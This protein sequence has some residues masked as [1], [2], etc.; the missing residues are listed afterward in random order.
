VEDWRF[1]PRIPHLVAA[2]LGMF[3]GVAA[4]QAVHISSGK[5][6]TW[7]SLLADVLILGIILLIVMY[8]NYMK[9]MSLEGIALLSAALA[10]WGPKGIA[11]LLERFKRVVL[12]TAD[13][14]LRQSVGQSLREAE[15][16]PL[17]EELPEDQAKLLDRLD[18][19]P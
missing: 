2:V 6:P 5:W 11:T 16:A 4:K 15:S 8:V 1:D 18:D 10:M 12:T 9:P 14:S 17:K 13:Q 7:K 3:I 19:I